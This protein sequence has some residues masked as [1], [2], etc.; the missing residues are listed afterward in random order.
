MLIENFS[1]VL[2]FLQGGLTPSIF[3]FSGF[4]S[5]FSRECFRSHRSHF[6]IAPLGLIVCVTLGALPMPWGSLARW[7]AFL[8]SPFSWRLTRPL[9]GCSPCKIS[10]CGGRVCPPWPDCICCVIMCCRFLGGTCSP[11]PVGLIRWNGDCL[12]SLLFEC[13]LGCALCFSS[14]TIG[15]LSISLPFPPN[16][17]LSIILFRIGFAGRKE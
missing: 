10:Y 2:L 1:I 15:V 11:F 6:Y 12:L 5:M 16:R 4:S 14:S 7:L 8:I 9:H 3:G 13:L 17:P